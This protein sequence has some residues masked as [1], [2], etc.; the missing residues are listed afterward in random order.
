MTYPIFSM[1]LALEVMT[2]VEKDIASGDN[3]VDTG[4]NLTKLSSTSR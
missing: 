3:P 4:D 1:K 2:L